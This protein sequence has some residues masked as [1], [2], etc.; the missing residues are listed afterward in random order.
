M[1]I[2]F[3]SQGSQDH[4]NIYNIIKGTSMGICV[5]FGPG[6]QVHLVRAFSREQLSDRNVCTVPNYLRQHKYLTMLNKL[7]A[8]PYG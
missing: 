6:E 3:S 2:Q 4:L 7:V 1:I 5:P 8:R